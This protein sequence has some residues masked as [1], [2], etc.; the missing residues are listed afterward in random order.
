[1]TSSLSLLRE[2]RS[3][4][5][6]F[7]KF[8]TKKSPL[9]GGSNIARISLRA[10]NGLATRGLVTKGFSDQPKMTLPSTNLLCD[11]L[12]RASPDAKRL[13]HL[14]NTHTLRELP[15]NLPLGRAVDLRSAEL[16]ALRHGTLEPCFDALANHRPLE[17]GKG[18][19]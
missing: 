11:A 10:A 6:G 8:E 15:S 1:M 17:L 4:P 5:A 3:R 2:P 9:P 7:P 14:Q 18:A 12:H 13:G 16:H 19:G